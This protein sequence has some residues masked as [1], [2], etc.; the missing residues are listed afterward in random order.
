[1]ENLR[2]IETSF[3][4][5]SEF[6]SMPSKNVS[7]RELIVKILGAILAVNL[8]RRVYDFTSGEN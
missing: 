1:M 6:L 7:L 4:K 2:R 8:D 5:F 3:S